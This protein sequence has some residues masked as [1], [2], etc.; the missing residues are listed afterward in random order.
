MAAA[1]IAVARAARKLKVKT[2]TK[3]RTV[4]QPRAIPSVQEIDNSRVKRVADR[5]EARTVGLYLMIGLIA[6][7]CCIGVAYQQ[8][9]I[10]KDGYDI[11]D[12]KTKRDDLIQENKRLASQMAALRNPERISNYASASL[13]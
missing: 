5:R 13:G 1:A 11:A 9:A 6:F 3:L 4:P 10:V 8:F 12:L 2:G 7:A